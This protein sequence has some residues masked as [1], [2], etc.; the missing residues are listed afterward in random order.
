MDA[1]VG[2]Y[3]LPPA[4]VLAVGPLFTLL[5]SPFVA[6]LWRKLGRR[7]PGVAFKYAFAFALVGSAYAALAGFSVSTPQLSVLFLLFIVAAFYLADLIGAPAAIS[8]VT[9]KAPRA[10][11]SQ[12]VSVHYLS[13]SI[14]A[15]LS[16]V[17]A[18]AYQP[19]SAVMYFGITA[20]ACFGL[21]GLLCGA[22]RFIQT[23]A[24]S[25][26]ERSDDL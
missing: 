1:S 26:P 21:A 13:F 19:A 10:F 20:T 25:L 15:A 18:Q 24:Q 11:R 3:R 2:S 23:E 4:T 22:A 17:L 9:A 8:F 12:M 16:G 7:Q 14:G 6:G 5:F